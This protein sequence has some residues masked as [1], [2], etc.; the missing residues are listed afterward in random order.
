MKQAMINYI[1]NEKYDE[2]YT[3]REAIIPVLKYLDKN[4]I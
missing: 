3:P 4:N 1:K 2:L